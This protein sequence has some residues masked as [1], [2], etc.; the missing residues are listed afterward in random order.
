MNYKEKMGYGNVRLPLAGLEEARVEI[1]YAE[2][3][4]CKVEIGFMLTHFESGYSQYEMKNFV[5]QFEQHPEIFD[6]KRYPLHI[7]LKVKTMGLN[8]WQA[9]RKCLD[10]IAGT[11]N[12]KQT[13]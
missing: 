2:N 10:V 12:A 4:N 9:T 13:Y 11:L 1:D 3:R 7:D 5:L 6:V 8:F